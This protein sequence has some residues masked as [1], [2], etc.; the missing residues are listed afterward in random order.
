MSPGLVKLYVN[1]SAINKRRMRRYQNGG[2]DER[3][4]TFEFIFKKL[5]LT[6]TTEF[7]LLKKKRCFVSLWGKKSAVFN[8]TQ[9]RHHKRAL[10]LRFP[11]LTPNRSSYM[12]GNAY[13]QIRVSC[14][15]T[16]VSQTLVFAT[17]YIKSHLFFP[18]P[19]ISFFLPLPAL[20]RPIR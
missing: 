7:F 16:F 5:R 1:V 6:K 2:G 8:E 19:Y 20:Y 14:K 15:Y 18:S 12:L 13:K 10:S 9:I 4:A 11:K 17:I 3:E